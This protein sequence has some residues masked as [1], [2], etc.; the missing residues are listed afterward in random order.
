MRRAGEHAGLERRNAGAGEDRDAEEKP[1][2]ERG[3]GLQHPVRRLDRAGKLEFRL[4]LGIEHAPIGADAAFEGLPRL[5]ER[6]DDR[7][8]DAHGVGA[9]DEVADDLGLSQRIGHGVLAVETRARPAKLGD[10]DA[11]AG[12]GLAQPLVDLHRVI[13]RDRARQPFPVGQ[14]VHGEIVDGGDELRMLEPDVPHLGGG[15]RHRDLALHLLDLG[16]QILDAR[17]AI[18]APSCRYSVS[19]PTMML[20]MLR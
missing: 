15:H 9:G 4:P 2:G 13:D 5:V 17:P 1:D 7:I 14:D 16:D 3:H 6:L 12:I 11:L 10:H 19:L 20:S 18:E 8:V